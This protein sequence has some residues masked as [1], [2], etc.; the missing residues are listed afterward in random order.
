[1]NFASEYSEECR[2]VVTEKPTTVQFL[3]RKLAQECR[4]D[5]ATHAYEILAS[6]EKMIRDDESAH[7]RTDCI[8]L[9]AENDMIKLLLGD[10]KK[11]AWEALKVK[12]KPG[13]KPKQKEPK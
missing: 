10:F 1:M 7:L 11:L 6:F 9:Q 2:D 3:V 13:R 8:R 4:L 5:P 12:A